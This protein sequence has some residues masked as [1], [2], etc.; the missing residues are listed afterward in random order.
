MGLSVITAEGAF[1]Q[2]WRRPRYPSFLLTVL[3]A[4]ISGSMFN[5]AGVLLVLTRTHS[6]PVAGITAAAGVVP[7]ALSG[8]L[9]GAWLDVARRRRVLIVA[10]QL[11]SVVGLVA[12]VALAG[13]APDWTVPAVAVLY[14]L[15]RPFSQGSFFSTLADIAGA[16]LLD[17]A[18]TIEATSLNLAIVVGPAMAGALAGVIGAAET[19]ELQ[20]VLTVVVAALVAVNPAFDVRPVDRPESV[21]HALRTGLRALS[22][23]RA[24]LATSFSSSLAAFSWG[25]MLVGFPLYA[26]QTLHTAA[27]AS[28]YLW[29]A[30]AGGSILGTFV[31]HGPP[32]LRRVGFS[33]GVLGLSALLWPLAAT[34]AVG[35]ALI[36]FTGFLEGPAYS[37]TIALRQRHAPPAARAQVMTTVTSISQLM[38]SAGAAL[39]GAIHHPMTLIAMFVCVNLIAAAGA[40]S[41]G[42]LA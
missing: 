29:A 42:P 36:G 13:H 28:G 35:I 26:A 21:S 27:H 30:V 1:R 2:L 41:R 6:A 17:Q 5:T 16:E 39:G 15:T 37:G 40:V 11:L 34:L 31:L 9:L 32:G 18:S 14:S 20:A 7:A 3:F 12:V 24:L 38:L 10:D 8:P 33:Y 22:R 25:L 4:R 19:V 23:Q